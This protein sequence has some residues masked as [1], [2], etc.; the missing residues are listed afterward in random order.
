M[1]GPCGY[2]GWSFSW[3]SVT[4]EKF[5]QSKGWFILAIHTL[6]GPIVAGLPYSESFSAGDVLGLYIELSPPSPSSLLPTRSETAKYVV[7][8]GRNY[9]EEKDFSERPR[10]PNNPQSKIICY[11]NGVCMVR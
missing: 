4:G 7:Y 5:H 6:P 10:P 2:D 8:K 3:R 9:F 11:K 1:Q